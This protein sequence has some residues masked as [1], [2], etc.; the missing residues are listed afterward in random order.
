MR[1]PAP[2]LS[3]QS[4]QWHL[5]HAVRDIESLANA[6]DLTLDAIPTDFPLL[7]PQPYLARIQKGNPNDPLLRQVL[8]VVS[9]NQAHTGY[10]ADPLNELG[11]TPGK[12]ILH[13]YQGRAL[14]IAS[15]SCAVNCRYCFRRH[16]PYEQFRPSPREWQDVLAYL[17]EHTDI[18]EVLLSGGDP[19]MLRDNY[20]A[21]YIRDLEA[22]GHID[23]V[24]I[25]TRLPIVIPTRI[26]AALCETL[27][28]TR[29]HA[30]M[31]VHANHANELNEDVSIA[32]QRLTSSGV[33]LLNQSVLLRGVNDSV[34]SLYKLSRRLF[35]CRVMPYYLHLLD[36]VQGAAHFDIP[37]EE[38]ITLHQ[39]LR[40]RLPGY[41]VPGL[42]AEVPGT[43]AK[44]PV[45]R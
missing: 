38:A 7:V 13:K 37:Q 24:R 21:N 33:H 4:W 34:D 19:L 45:T 8:P 14:V 25:H 10:S 29:L 44:Q 6:L 43:G 17:Q 3:E 22:I 35:D 42:V 5:Q 26:T 28:S 23:T 32:M 30:V 20:L 16:F 1:K 18:H 41:L 9:E 39:A 2:L 15:T 36:K 40:D 12:G 11:Q 27:S 31:V